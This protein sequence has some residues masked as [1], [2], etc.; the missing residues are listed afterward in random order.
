[1]KSTT[2]WN[3]GGN[4]TNTSGFTALPGGIRE[5]NGDFS[6]LVNYA[7]FW[8]SA[9]YDTVSAWDWALG[10]Y[11]SNV[12]NYGDYKYY[13]ISVRCIHGEYVN[14]PPAPPSSPQPSDGVINQPINTTLSWVCSDPENDLLTYDVYFGTSNPPL[15]ASSGQTDATYNPGTLAYSTPY[16]WKV[17]A[18]DNHSNLTEG[19][20]WSFT[21]R[22]WQC[23]D[24]LV[25]IR[26]G[27]TYT[28]VQIGTQCW[29]K[30]NLNIGTVIPGA[31]NMT[32]NSIIEKYCY[33][34]S[35]ANCTTYGGLYQW[36]EMMQYSITPGVQ[37]ICPASWH[38][39]TD[40]ELTIINYLF[41]RRRCCRR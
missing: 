41:R 6:N 13:G 22:A 2:G 34:N 17:V 8:T 11:Q 37:G 40:S 23:A 38:L 29:M 28:T 14:Q 7:L 33:N 31:N 3:P 19:P 36:N 26:D 24:P 39:P 18:H 9:E 1:M 21:T 4:G 10:Y 32:N 15:L 35:T 5:Y 20:V 25:D 12:G 30:Q 27:Q 16:Y